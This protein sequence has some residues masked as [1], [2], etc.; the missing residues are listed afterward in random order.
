MRGSAGTKL[1]LKLSSNQV[2]S[3]LD[4]GRGFVSILKTFHLHFAERRYL[5]HLFIKSLPVIL[6]SIFP[7]FPGLTI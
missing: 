1:K 6:T 4:K 3:I 7:S 5:D 2:L